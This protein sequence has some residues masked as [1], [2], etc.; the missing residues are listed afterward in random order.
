MDKT[1]EKSTEAEILETKCNQET[2]IPFLDKNMKAVY[3]PYYSMKE[4]AGAD[5]CEEKAGQR[6]EPFGEIKTTR[7]CK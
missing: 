3:S 1:F 5:I 2:P 4:L 6:N 7:M